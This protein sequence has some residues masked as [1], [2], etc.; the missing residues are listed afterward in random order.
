MFRL[1]K[2]KWFW[3]L[4]A[5]VAA[6]VVSRSYSRGPKIEPGSFLL[7][8][9]QGKYPEGPPGFLLGR[10]L[11]D[12]E[13]Y[14]Q[15]LE[16]LRKA[17]ADKRIVGI[18]LRV[19]AADVG[20]AQA[21]EIRELLKAARS[22][23]KRVVAFL[24]G[25]I[26]SANIAYY[27]SSAAETIYLP[28]GHANMLTGLSA[29]FVFLG[30]V[31][32]NL[33]VEMEVEQIR[34]YKTFGDTVA[35]K[36]MSDAHRE[37]A[38]WLLDGLNDEFVA[39][40]AEGRNSSV[41]EILSTI[42]TCPSTANEYIDAG[43]ADRVAFYD[44]MLRELGGRRRAVVVEESDYRRVAP[45]SVGLGGG[46][47]IAV[48]HAVGTIVS[49]DSPRG[50][51]MGSAVGSRTLERAFRR[52]T[53]DDSIKAVVFRIDSPGGSAAASD[54]VWHAVRVASEKKPIIASMG[55]VAASGGYY[56]AAAADRIVAEPGTLT[57]SI[58]VVLMKPDVSGLL[59]RVGVGTDAIGRGRYSRVMDF[60]KPMDRAELALVKNQMKG[61]YRRFLERV[62]EGRKMDV[63]EVDKLG[64]GRVWTGLQAKDRGLVDSIGGL[65]S[66][67]RT[68]A[69]IAGIP[70]PAQVELV[71]LPRPESP[72]REL[73]GSYGIRATELPVPVALREA[74]E[75]SLGVY[76]RLD[77]GVHALAGTRIEIR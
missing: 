34:E 2:R 20:W 73:L 25:D 64:G 23:G 11:D 76:T 41:P 32:E 13:S 21:R 63:E 69:D 66:A 19:G 57:G 28:P 52:A 38:N 77:A 24:D 51:A 14:A 29:H 62:A 3:L 65:A 71:H 37:M 55:N 40:I 36:E 61:I 56:I 22:A 31:W 44:E 5:V 39:A 9:F 53:E 8:D 30:G 68:A 10:F 54:A 18:I 35:R 1:L 7:V 12:R 42:D 67:V 59:G 72:L 27:V 16:S 47:K 75:G 58:G 4:L 49:G 15:L 48:I 43:L 60:T 6:L 26:G 70:E 17:S 33:D 46:D 50:G 74:I 45:E